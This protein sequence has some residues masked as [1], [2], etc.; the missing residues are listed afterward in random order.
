MHVS[1][2]I[3]IRVYARSAAISRS[4]LN[5]SLEVARKAI[6]YLENDYFVGL[7]E[8]VPPKTDLVALPVTLSG[9][10]EN[11]GLTFYRESLI[12]DAEDKTP[13]LSKQNFALVISHE[14]SHFFF[15]NY[16]TMRYW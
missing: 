5:F 4:Y 10:S 12:Y 1:F 7:S 9:A 8:A 15:G 2:I 6:D 11:W 16:V 14:I 3:K 13:L